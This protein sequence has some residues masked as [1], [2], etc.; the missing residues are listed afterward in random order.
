MRSGQLNNKIT[1]QEN[2]GTKDSV[3]QIVESWT[4]LATVWARVRAIGGGETITTKLELA[5]TDYLINIRYRTDI[6]TLHRIQLE[7][8]TILDVQRVADMDGRK[9]ELELKCLERKPS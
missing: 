4:T 5:T 9:R 2:T 6:T 7:N 8:G 1:I 3:G